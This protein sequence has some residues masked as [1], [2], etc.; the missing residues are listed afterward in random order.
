MSQENSI[1]AA[2]LFSL[3]KELGDC[4]RLVAVSKFHP[5][6][7]IRE[8]YRAGQRIFGENRAQELVAKYDELKDE[9]KDVEWHFIGSLQSNKVKFLV[10]FVSLIQSVSSQKLLDEIEKQAAKID[11]VVDILLEVHVAKEETKSGFSVNDV[12]QVVKTF[13]ESG[14]YRHIRLRGLMTMATNTDDEQLIRHEFHSVSELFYRI[15]RDFALPD[16][17][18]LSMGMS[19]DYPLAIAEGA[20]LVR[21]GTSI[22][23]EREYNVDSNKK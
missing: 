9:L 15:K 13:I 23:G 7:S 12:Y 14:L 16:F 3:K 1:I 18:E 22:F 21:I 10:P 2:R 5:S 8:A 6:G 20:T 19:N 11:R 17:D 4:C